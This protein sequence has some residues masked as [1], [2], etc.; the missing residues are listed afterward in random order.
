[1]GLKYQGRFWL[2]EDGVRWDGEVEANALRQGENCKA[3][4]DFLTWQGILCL[5]PG[6]ASA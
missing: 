1:M 3:K 5:C 2:A 4:T 6:M